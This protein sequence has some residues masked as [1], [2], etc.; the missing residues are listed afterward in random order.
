MHSFL[1]FKRRVEERIIQTF[2]QETHAMT[3]EKDN[4]QQNAA[5]FVL[6]CT[7]AVHAIRGC[8]MLI[9]RKEV[10]KKSGHKYSHTV[11]TRN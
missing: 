9:K 11:E 2:N 4:L 10:M 6:V 5:N 1:L 7:M 8:C 3:P